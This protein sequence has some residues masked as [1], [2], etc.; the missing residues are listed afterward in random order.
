[1]IN[2]SVQNEAQR[3]RFIDEKGIGMTAACSRSTHRAAALAGED[4]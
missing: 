2:T 1:M 4:E 3:E